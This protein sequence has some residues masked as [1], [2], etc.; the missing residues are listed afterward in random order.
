MK[1]RYCLLILFV[2]I[3]FL[4]QRIYAVIIKVPDH[5]QSIQEAIEHAK[6]S[7]T[8]LVANGTYHENLNIKNKDI[9]LASNFLYSQD[10]DD[11]RKTIIDG[12][13]GLFGI[14]VINT[15]SK[16]CIFGFTIEN[17]EDGVSVRSKISFF[18]NVVKNCGDGLDYESKS[19]GICR[20]NTLEL[21][22]DDGVDLDNDVDIIIERNI[23]KNNGDDGIE[24]RLQPYSG[25]M[26]KNDIRNNFII[27]SGED[28]IQLIDYPDSSHR[29]ISIKNNIISNSAK[30]AIGCMNNGN[31][32]ENYEAAEMVERVLII[33][34]TILKNTYGICGGGNSI[35]LNNVLSN[36]QYTALKGIRGNS[37]VAFQNLY[38][39][40]INYTDCNLIKNT[41]T[42]NDP[43][44]KENFDL[45]NDSPLIGRG[46]T[47]YTYK[48]KVYGIDTNVKQKSVNIGALNTGISGWMKNI[49]PF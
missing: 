20:N 26:V 33:N 46:T 42:F 49:G 16:T 18:H 43:K 7:D 21:N 25:K 44:L 24:I 32:R 40:G 48:D 38:L 12:N 10:K 35:V 23:I 1:P 8:I 15:T 17:A 27:N 9:V 41:I 34:N 31:T 11:I 36:T 5:F 2:S 13:G 47:T 29:F 6:N 28:G 3:I 19:G 30:A 14:K 45:M 39:N 4:N 37:V 22:N